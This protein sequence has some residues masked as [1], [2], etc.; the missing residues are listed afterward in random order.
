MSFSEDLRERTEFA[1]RI[2]EKYLPGEGGYAGRVIEAARYSALS[3]GKRLRPVILRE[4][5]I[6]FGG[7]GEVV[8]P[9]MA[10][11]EFIHNYSLVHDDL[12]AMDNDFLRRGKKTTHAVYGAGMATLA[13]DMLLNLAFETAFKAFDLA[14]LD[15]RD[16]VIRSLKIL[17]EKAGYLGMLGGQ[18]ADVDSEERNLETDMDKLLFIHENKTAALIECALMIGAALAGA[19]D[20][21]IELMRETGSKVGLAFQI[22]DDILDVIG[23][24]EKLGKTVGSDSINGK[25][26]YVT[27]CGLE[28]AEADQKRLSIE[29]AE[30]LSL[31]GGDNG[32]LKELIIRL[33]DREM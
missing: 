5:F 9:F 15:R 31:A 3:G 11:I 7:E 8:E 10:A 26:T 19:G 30:K 1:E 16:G 23:D 4:A 27:L 28:K 6:M 24:Q 33:A 25:E 21:E 2:V 20:N 22:K 17:G 32:F 29:A 18:S 14:S 12:P 13:G